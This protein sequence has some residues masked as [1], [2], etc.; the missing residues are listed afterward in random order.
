MPLTKARSGTLPWKTLTVSVFSEVTNSVTVSPAAGAANSAVS[1]RT[2]AAHF[3]VFG[4]IPSSL[5]EKLSQNHLPNA[6][7][8]SGAGARLIGVEVHDRQS[9]LPGVRLDPLDDHPADGGDR[10]AAE[11]L[12]GSR[13]PRHRPLPRGRPLTLPSPPLGGGA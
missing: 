10:N 2:A 1:M 11:P 7:G 3:A 13:R 5:S 8:P 4:I 12:L 9:L 6:T